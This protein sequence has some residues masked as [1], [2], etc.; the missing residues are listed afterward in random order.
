M[1]NAIEHSTEQSN[2]SP[3]RAKICLALLAFMGFSLGCSEFMVIGIESELAADFNVP[4]STIGHLVSLFAL[5]YAILTPTLALTTGRFKRYT[6]LKVYCAIF[7]IGNVIAALAADYGMLLLSR[8]VTGGISGA[9]L[10]VGTTYIP[11][12]AGPK[13][14]SAMISVVYAAFS[15]AMVVAT[16]LGKL[17]A[18]TFNWHVAMYVALGMAAIVCVALVALMPKTGQTDEP[19]TFKEQAV[20]LRE[21]TVIAGAGIFVFGVGAVYTFYGFITPYLEQILGF[22]TI[23]ASSTLMVF[24]FVGLVSNLIGGWVDTR[25]GMPA[26][27]FIFIALAAVLGGVSLVGRSFPIALVLVFCVALLMYSF[28][29]AC[30]T[31]FMRIARERHPKA[32]TLASSLEPLTFNIG[33]AFGSAIGGVVIAGPGIIHCGSVGAV[34]ALIATVFSILTARFARRID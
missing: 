27:P 3:I 24:G 6:L 1:S 34:L 9:L 20:L 16:S 29:I 22:D 11:E 15:M 19:S 32:L 10:A 2:V 30:I 26:L 18:D 23:A 7:F 14:M 13:H 12:L 21:P 33:I 17:L 31:Q 25:F 4:L 28:S 8:I 5:P